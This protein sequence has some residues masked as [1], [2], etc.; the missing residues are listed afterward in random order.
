M[1]HL[2]RRDGTTI[3]LGRD[4]TPLNRRDVDPS[5]REIS[6]QHARVVK[7]GGH[8]WIED[9]RSSN[10]TYLNDLRIFSPQVLRPG[11][12]IKLGRTVLQVEGQW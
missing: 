12:E 9:M 4:T 1:L 6:R 2:E 8:Y 7:R 3:R 11:D 5:D 10:G